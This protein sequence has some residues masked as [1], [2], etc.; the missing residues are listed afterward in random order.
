MEAIETKHAKKLLILNQESLL[1]ELKNAKSEVILT[2][3]KFKHPKTNEPRSFL[4]MPNFEFYELVKYEPEFSSVFIGNFVQ[5]NINMCFATKFNVNYFLISILHIKQGEYV[6]LDNMF[7]NDEITNKSV[8]LKEF[9]KNEQLDGL[10]DLEKDNKDDVKVK[11]NLDKCLNWLKNKVFKLE[12]YLKSVDN[13]N[14]PKDIKMIKNSN[15]NKNEIL[16]SAFEIIAQYINPR[17][18]QLLIK[19]LNLNELIEN[20]KPTECK[21]MKS[22]VN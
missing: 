3:K 14:G 19:E 1:S 13:K 8:N 4:M 20:V 11:F 2:V 9:I 15:E 12:V 21:R 22:S 7:L 17:L 16:I 18:H 6:S 10:F 5:S